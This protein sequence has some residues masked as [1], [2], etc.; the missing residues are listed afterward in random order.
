MCDSWGLGHPQGP[1]SSV[2]GAP[3]GEAGSLCGKPT[4]WAGVGSAVSTLGRCR[5]VRSMGR[6]VELEPHRVRKADSRFRS[7]HLSQKV[8]PGRS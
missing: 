2:L 4:W 6:A 3:G 7:E 8:L 5:A 1:H